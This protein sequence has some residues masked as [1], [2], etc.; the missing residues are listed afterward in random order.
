[1][2]MIWFTNG[3][4]TLVDD[5]DYDTVS[6]EKWH[7]KEKR[8]VLYVAGR[9]VVNEEQVYTYIHRVIMSASL[10]EFV[11]H[12]DGNPL[13]NQRYNLRI[14]TR[15]ENMMNREKRKT[16]SSKHKGV[17]FNKSA[18]KWTARVALNNKRIFLGY[19]VSEIEAAKAYDIKAKELHGEF[20][21]LNFT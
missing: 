13:N 9:V 3:Q 15:S 4:F 19:F 8:G 7:S 6:K 2:K 18:G 16:G 21:K 14:C 1:M 12:I 17:V 20:A 5:E 10:D 11:D